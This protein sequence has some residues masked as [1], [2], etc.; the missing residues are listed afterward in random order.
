MA[1]IA[2][3]VVPGLPHHLT[4][5]GNRKARIFDN[6]GFRQDYLVLVRQYAKRHGVRI[7]KI[8]DGL[9]IKFSKISDGKSVT[10][11]ELSLT[12]AAR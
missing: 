12:A 5:R 1:R 6:D 8:S 7:W 9:R 3:I 4:Q 10:D 11:Y 2:R